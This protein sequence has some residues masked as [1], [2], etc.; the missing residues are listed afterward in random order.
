[1]DTLDTVVSLALQYHFRISLTPFSTIDKINLSGESNAL[2][3]C[4]ATTAAWHLK[5][6]FTPPN[7]K[8][9]YGTCKL[10]TST[11]ISIQ[12]TFENSYVV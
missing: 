10:E 1:M 9:D 7:L 11:S 5:F 8:K 6:L 2:D 4:I 12:R 3:C